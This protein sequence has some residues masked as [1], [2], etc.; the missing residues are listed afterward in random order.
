M[1][2][3]VCKNGHVTEDDSMGF[4]PVCGHLL[5][6]VQATQSTPSTQSVEPPPQPALSPTAAQQAAERPEGAK[7]SFGKWLVSLWR[8]QGCLGRVVLLVVALLVLGFV[9]TMVSI[10]CGGIASVVGRKGTATPT[11]ALGP[12]ATY[13]VW[14][15]WTPSATPTWTPTDIPTETS[16]LTLTP[17]RTLTPT[18]TLTPTVTL[19]PTRTLT[20]T[21]TLTPVPTVDVVAVEAREF[22][23]FVE[24]KWELGEAVDKEVQKL[25]KAMSEGESA[26]LVGL[27]QLAKRGR[28]TWR[29][30]ASDVYQYTLSAKQLKEAQEHLMQSAMFRN[31]AYKKLMVYLDSGKTSDLAEYKENWDTSERYMISGLTEVLVLAQRDR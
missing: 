24:G 20:P 13:R 2:K 28:D 23:A 16:T 30:I 29:Q 19:T 31:D 7:K 18:Q 25:V 26:D 15:T 6:P 21:Q 12:T 14:P 10:V 8:K 22:Q 4:C 17:T 3:R 27:Y 1:A 11:M 5:P 9:L